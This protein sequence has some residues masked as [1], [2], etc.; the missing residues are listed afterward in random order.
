MF[1]RLG[2]GYP[3]GARA[4]RDRAAGAWAAHGGAEIKTV[5]DAFIVAFESAADA[6]AASVAAQRGDGRPSVAVRRRHARVRVGVHAGMAF[7]HDGDY[8]A[9]ASTRRPGSSTPPTAAR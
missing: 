1:R 4:A 3:R 7:P 9:L 2:E 6:M 8:M 5:A